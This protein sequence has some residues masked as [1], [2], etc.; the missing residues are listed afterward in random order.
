MTSRDAAPGERYGVALS[1]GIDSTLV[2]A[3]SPGD[4]IAYHGRVDHEGCDE[5]AYAR[6]ATAK[7]PI[8]LADF[9]LCGR[10]FHLQLRTT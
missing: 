3:L 8:V 4:R 1:G 7:V 2:A 9:R 6:A 5:S 10:G